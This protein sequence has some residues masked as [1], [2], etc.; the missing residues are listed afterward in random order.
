MLSS[1]KAGVLATGMD[2]WLHRERERGIYE[3]GSPLPARALEDMSMWPSRAR[4]PGARIAWWA[5]DGRKICL[6]EGG[7]RVKEDISNQRGEC[8]DV[9][10]AR[11]GYGIAGGSTSSSSSS[12]VVCSP[13]KRQVGAR[14]GESSARDRGGGASC[15]VDGREREK[16]NSAAGMPLSLCLSLSLRRVRAACSR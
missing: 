4:M 2:T 7:R 6:E 10:L 1:L 3:E 15:L 16:E 9:M 14:G 11:S 13:Q 12:S 5:F 8:G